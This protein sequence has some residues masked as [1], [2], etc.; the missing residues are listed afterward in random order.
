MLQSVVIQCFMG[1]PHGLECFPNK[2]QLCFLI[3][4][5]THQMACQENVQPLKGPSSFFMW[6]YMRYLSIGS[7]FPAADGSSVRQKACMSDVFCLFSREISTTDVKS[8][9]IQETT[10]LLSN[11]LWYKVA[12]LLP[13]LHKHNLKM[14]KS[15]TSSIICKTSWNS[16]PRLTQNSPC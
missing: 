15:Q 12:C 6:G 13:Q 11:G 9:E 3:T 7:V 8:L 16:F 10:V 2:T 5:G 4:Q 1:K 14:N